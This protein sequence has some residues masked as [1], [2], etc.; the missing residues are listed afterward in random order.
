MEGFFPQV[1]FTL[2]GIPIRDTVVFTWIMMALMAGTG[3]LL[4]LV[5]PAAMEMLSRSCRCWVRWRC[6][7][8]W[9]T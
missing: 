9:P 5:R 6:S 2:F 4:G 8:P 3:A 1:A 7:S